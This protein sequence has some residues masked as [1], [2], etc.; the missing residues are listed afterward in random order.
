MR[1]VYAQLIYLYEQ[2]VYHD[3]S[4]GSVQSIFG[5]VH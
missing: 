5:C 3:A 4:Y 1:N 2:I